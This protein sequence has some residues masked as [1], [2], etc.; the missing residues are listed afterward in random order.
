MI[1]LYRL[2]NKSQYFVDISNGL[3]VSDG[4]AMT[5]LIRYLRFHYYHSV[6]TFAGGITR[7]VSLC[8][9]I[10]KVYTIYLLLK[11]KMSFK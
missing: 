9:G 8:V 4:M 11:L 3:F 6:V 1:G 2:F 7:P 5:W 10:D